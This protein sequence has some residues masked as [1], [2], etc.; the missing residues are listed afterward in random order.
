MKWT[1][2]D[3]DD[4]V[5]ARTNSD[6]Y[7]KES[8]VYVGDLAVCRWPN[9][10]VCQVHLDD[11]PVCGYLIDTVPVGYPTPA[12]APEDVPPTIT[13]ALIQ[14]DLI[15]ADVGAIAKRRAWV[16]GV[17]SFLLGAVGAGIKQRYFSK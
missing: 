9:G 4:V 2:V 8:C 5:D 10:L 7:G 17:V 12:N 16:V 6:A 13:M 14:G 11:P 1:P 15:P 3:N